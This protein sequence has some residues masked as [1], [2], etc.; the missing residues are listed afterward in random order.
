MSWL[1]VAGGR[2]LNQDLVVALNFSVGAFFV[3]LFG[4]GVHVF[5]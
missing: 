5:G 3:L 2:R 4:F 1:D